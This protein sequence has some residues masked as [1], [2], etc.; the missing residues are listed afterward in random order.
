VGGPSSLLALLG[1]IGGE[2]HESRE[3]RTSRGARESRAD[4]TREAVFEVPVVAQVQCCF[5][6]LLLGSA[7]NQLAALQDDAV[8]VLGKVLMERIDP[9][10]HTHKHT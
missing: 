3:T 5:N 8:V 10:S 7:A 2:N 1:E 4:I 9:R 6:R